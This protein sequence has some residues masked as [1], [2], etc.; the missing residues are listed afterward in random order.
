M[1][2]IDLEGLTTEQALALVEDRLN[3]LSRVVETLAE[4]HNELTV[5]VRDLEY[6]LRMTK[7]VMTGLE[8][9]FHQHL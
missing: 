6:T 5:R 3:T 2:R 9:N 1:G 4:S 7:Q 8:N